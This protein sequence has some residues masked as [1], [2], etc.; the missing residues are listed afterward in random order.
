MLFILFTFSRK[1]DLSQLVAMGNV[2]IV[3]HIVVYSL[4][5]GNTRQVRL[6]CKKFVRVIENHY[7][8][9]DVDNIMLYK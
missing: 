9:D 1:D 5:E 7:I 8:D 6:P 2:C 3:D 4:R